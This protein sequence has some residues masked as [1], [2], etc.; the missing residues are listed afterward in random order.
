[1]A[2]A[3]RTKAPVTVLAGFLGSG[4]STLLNRIFVEETL[5]ALSANGVCRHSAL[6]GPHPPPN[7]RSLAGAK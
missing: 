3:D 7:W 6:V 4:K 1:M 2:A 5:S